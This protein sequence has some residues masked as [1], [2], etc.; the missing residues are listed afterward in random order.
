MVQTYIEWY[1]AI[2]K[3]KVIQITATWRDLGN[4][5]MSKVSQSD[6]LW[7]FVVKDIVKDDGNKEHETGVE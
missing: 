3:D 7:P 2:R 5:I 4:I 6:K 1:L